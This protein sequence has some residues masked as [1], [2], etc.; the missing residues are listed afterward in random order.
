LFS[1]RRNLLWDQNFYNLS[2]SITSLRNEKP[3]FKVALKIYYMQTPFTQWMYFLLLQMICVADLHDGVNSYT[4]IILYV[5]YAF[6]N[7]LSFPHPIV[8]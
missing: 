1:K 3:Q 2:Q 4:A 7:F 5:L 6:V 8:W